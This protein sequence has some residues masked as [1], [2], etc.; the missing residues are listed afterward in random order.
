MVVT[1]PNRIISISDMW[2]AGK[3]L[4]EIGDAW[5]ISRERVRQL[6]S[7]YTSLTTKDGG[8]V[9]RGQIRAENRKK[10][11]L[12]KYGC[13]LEDYRILR[14]ASRKMRDEG[15]TRDTNLLGAY[16][17]QKTNSRTVQGVEWKLSLSQ[18]W[19]IWLVSGM[20]DKRGRSGY[21]MFRYDHNGPFE[22]G[23]VYIDTVKQYWAR[24]KGALN[25]QR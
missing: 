20:W 5:G 19:N 18:W 24:R 1:D 23:N 15:A 16:S 12:V 17:R 7:K 11:L 10:R 13:S 22:V 9:V 2:R 8:R 6:R 21:C 3:T 25:K 14:K 4:R